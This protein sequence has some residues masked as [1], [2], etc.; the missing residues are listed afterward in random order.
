M[1][2]WRFIL[3]KLIS[4]MKRIHH[5]SVTLSD[6]TPFNPTSFNVFSSNMITTVWFASAIFHQGGVYCGVQ[7]RL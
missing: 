2:D 6:L 5:S 4:Q 7:A 3:L 1:C